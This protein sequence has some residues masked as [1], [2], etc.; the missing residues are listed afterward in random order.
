MRIWVEVLS[1]WRLVIR[2]ITS[3]RWP[4]ERYQRQMCWHHEMRSG[5]SWIRQELVGLGQ[6]KRFWCYVC[7][8]VWMLMELVKSVDIVIN[9]PG[10]DNDARP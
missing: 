6:T 10:D 5:E 7:G 1:L 2:S 8:E 4:S 3:F 9:L